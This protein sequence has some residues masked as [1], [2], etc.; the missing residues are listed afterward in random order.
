LGFFEYNAAVMSRILEMAEMEWRISIGKSNGVI[1]T[2]RQ[3]FDLYTP[4]SIIPN[5][6][7]QYYSKIWLEEICPQLHRLPRILGCEKD[8]HG[9]LEIY[10]KRQK[11]IAFFVDYK[12]L[13]HKTGAILSIS[14]AIAS[15]QFVIAAR[16]PI[17][18]LNP[19]FPNY[20][21]PIS[22]ATFYTSLPHQSRRL[23]GNPY[24]W[25][26]QLHDY[27]ILKDLPY[28]MTSF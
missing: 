22:K 4:D 19:D 17:K 1:S 3:P 13:R 20:L 11:P 12:P 26:R 7:R 5:N 9:C 6:S 27:Q 24:F 16:Q 25:V 18:I 2:N 28:F 15:I 8:Q 14:H 10:D 23:V 21:M